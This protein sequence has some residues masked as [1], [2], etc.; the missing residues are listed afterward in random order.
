MRIFNDT[1]SSLCAN[2]SGTRWCPSLAEASS[3]SSLLPRAA[4]QANSNRILLQREPRNKWGWVRLAL[5]FSLANALSV[6]RGHCTSRHTEA[7][8]HD[9]ACY[10]HA[11]QT[12]S[13]VHV[14]YLPP[15]PETPKNS[16]GCSRK[17][18]SYSQLALHPK[19]PFIAFDRKFIG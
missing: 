9:P 19:R 13:P 11:Y 10:F 8:I 18:P 15:R 5:E 7:G 6:M 1:A 3:P 2:I 14:A 12:Y 4:T 16:V 17:H